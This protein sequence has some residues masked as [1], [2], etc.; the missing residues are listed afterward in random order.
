MTLLGFGDGW[1]TL[2]RAGFCQNPP[3][4]SRGCSHSAGNG[5][6]KVHLKRGGGSGGLLRA[7]QGRFEGEDRSPRW[8]CQKEQT[9][10]GNRVEGIPVNRFFHGE[11]T[12]RLSSMVFIA[13]GVMFLRSSKEDSTGLTDRR[14]RSRP[15]APRECHAM[16]QMA[17]IIFP[18]KG[19][20]QGLG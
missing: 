9:E 7:I 1:D 18:A 8:R 17:S 2:L 16:R 14:H 5:N 10:G 15:D 11:Q 4:S 3:V 6:P 12:S 20:V 13:M 19:K